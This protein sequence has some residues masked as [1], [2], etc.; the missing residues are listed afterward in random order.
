[1]S[2]MD[3][4]K[5]CLSTECL[6][7]QI[8]FHCLRMLRPPRQVARV[9]KEYRTVHPITGA[10]GTLAAWVACSSRDARTMIVQLGF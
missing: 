2:L 6:S 8:V 1:M 5:Y 3:R 10:A 4:P 9:Q 7:F